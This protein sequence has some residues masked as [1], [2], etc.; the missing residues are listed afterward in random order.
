MPVLSAPAPVGVRADAVAGVAAVV[1]PY[2][3]AGP[4]PPAFARHGWRTVAV[5]PEP[6]ARPLAYHDA[7]VPREFAATVVHRGLR[8]TVKA[9]RAMGVS[10]VVAGS[11]GGIHLAERIA[12]QLALPGADPVSWLLRCDRGAQAE[13]L[14]A[15]GIPA[16][17]GIRTTSLADALA[18]ARACPLPG[19]LLAPAA[20]G[21]PVGA[22]A[23][24]SELQISSVWP[25]LRRLAAVYSG[26][27][28]LVL[29][30]P[31]PLR[32][33][34]L[35]TTT[36]ARPGQRPEHAVTDAWA[37]VC[38]ADGQMERAD[39]MPAGGLLTRALSM[40]A[41]RALD[42]LG[43]VCGPATLRLAYPTGEG[44]DAADGPMVIS[45][46]TAPM[47]TLADEALT[48]AM[49]RDRYTDVVDTW[50]PPSPAPLVPAPTGQHI[51]RARLH[52][53]PAT[54][55]WLGRFLRQLPTVAAVHENPEPHTAAVASTPA[56]DEVVLSG[57]PR[58]TERDYRLIRALER[59]EQF[60]KDRP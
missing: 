37:D 11:A 9:L 18:W 45:A 6:K 13:A 30:E 19:Y 22:V 10:A 14:A 4:Y 60:L 7:A 46:V 15:H 20:T 58:E 40:A 2:D 54:R 33:Y 3:G 50:I 56:A 29:T 23:C 27:A 16:P 48:A 52:P 41:A 34:T 12:W 49:G 32:Q 38:G 53:S 1:A 31:L 17:R 28:H 59:T 24:T 44:M 21:I 36:T 35:N 39:L 26:A 25:A 5:V 55:P 47:T 51:V 8:R 42:A 43:V 57:D